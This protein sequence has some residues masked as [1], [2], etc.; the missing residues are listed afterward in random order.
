MAFC[1]AWSLRPE[2]R[3]HTRI[4]FARPRLSETTIVVLGARRRCSV[5][6]RG[7]RRFRASSQKSARKKR[8]GARRDWR[9][10]EFYFRE[11]ACGRKLD[12]IGSPRPLNERRRGIHLEYSVPA[13]ARP[14][15]VTPG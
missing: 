11:K 8:A 10:I 2:G 6:H 4:W 14:P 7:L 13:P 1:R 3:A 15:P 12:A 9:G 5:A